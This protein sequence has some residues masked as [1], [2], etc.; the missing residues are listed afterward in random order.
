MSV[1]GG[2]PVAGLILAGGKS[3]RMGRDKAGLKL[4]GET[5]L[6]RSRRV[7]EDVGCDPIMVSGGRVNGI[8]DNYPERGPLGGIQA[9]L[10]ILTQSSPE[11]T[12]GGRLVVIPVD[13]PKLTEQTLQPLLNLPTHFPVY[14]SNTALPCVLP[15][16]ADISNYLNECLSTKGSDCS[17][18]SLLRYF[19]AQALSGGDP[20]QLI[21]TNTPEQWR[22]AVK[23]ELL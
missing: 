7:L 9:G 2:F 21:N 12:A 18:M 11:I 14:F 22:A 3:T 19:N 15:V 8:V 17:V 20:Q 5:L 4:G 10:Q 6:A 16:T 13:M 1:Q 23:E